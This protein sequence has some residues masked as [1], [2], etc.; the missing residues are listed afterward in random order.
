MQKPGTLTSA[1]VFAVLHLC[2]VEGS[3]HDIEA[4]MIHLRGA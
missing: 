4:S 1:L 3:R 2:G